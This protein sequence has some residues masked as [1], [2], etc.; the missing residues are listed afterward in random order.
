MII[1]F[2][3]ETTGLLLPKGAP[4]CNQ[5]RIIE[6]AAIKTDHDFKE[7][8]RIEFFCNPGFKLPPEITKITGIKDSDVCSAKPFNWYVDELKEFFADCTH[9]IAHNVMF[10]IN[11]LRNDMDRAGALD[12]INW[13]VKYICTVEHTKHISNKRMNLGKAFTHFTGKPQVNS[14]RAMGDVEMLREL[15]E[16]LFRKGIICLS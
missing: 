7:A 16:I 14:H 15:A 13:G 2:D 4:L 1:L 6:F 10:D 8:D 11:M 9:I 12:C 5:P 3:T